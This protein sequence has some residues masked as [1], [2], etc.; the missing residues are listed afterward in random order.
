MP[1]YRITTELE[2][3][4]YTTILVPCIAVIEVD[5][6]QSLPKSFKRSD[7]EPTTDGED[8]LWTY[9]DHELI[10]AYTI[11]ASEVTIEEIDDFEYKE[12]SSPQ[13]YDPNQITLFN[14]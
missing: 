9:D 4:V 3:Q 6:E 7:F 11:D 12:T 8:D 5:N 1:K 14:D 13:F 10:H 2:Y